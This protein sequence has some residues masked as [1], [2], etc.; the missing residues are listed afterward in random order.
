MKVVVIGS[1]P[2]GLMCAIKASEKGHDVTIL[3]KNEKAGKKIYITG[4]GRCN[5]T[6]N[7]DVNEFMKNVV[8]NNRF[9]YSSINTFK[10]SDTINFFETRG[11]KLVTERGNRVFPLS[12][13]A[14]DITRCL[15]DECNKNKVRIYYHT[16][17]SKIEKNNDQFTIYY[18]NGLFIKCDKLVIATGGLSYPLTGSTGDGYNYA[19][20]FGHQIIDT[21]PSLCALKINDK[22]SYEAEGLTLKNVCLHGYNDKVK[23]S[24]EGEMNFDKGLIDGPI[25]LKMSTH[26]QEEQNIRLYLDL[27][28]GLNNEQLN[29]RLIRDFSQNPNISLKEELVKLLPIKMIKDF[30]FRIKIDGN[31]KLNSIRKEQREKIVNYLKRYDLDYI[32][33]SSFNRA[34]VTRGGVNIKEINPKTFESKITPNLYFIGEVLDVDAYTGGFNMQIALSTGYCCGNNMI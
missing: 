17:I 12:Y 3:E 1:G 14:S 30:L 4:K 2:S 19:K 11:V 34:I 25:V 22:V 23:Y 9:L 32:G 24:F 5:V 7:C 31:I 15:L 21:Y 29:E 33:L 27:K 16:A 18:N 8:R 13:K 20:Q 26:I 10:P 28:I 6:N